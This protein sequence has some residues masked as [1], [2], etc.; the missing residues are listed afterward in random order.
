MGS[1]VRRGAGWL[2]FSCKKK[3]SEWGNDVLM[4]DK[5][6][7]YLAY[8]QKYPPYIP[9]R[10]RRPLKTHRFNDNIYY[11]KLLFCPF[12]HMSKR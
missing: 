11:H 8:H 9:S 12:A 5:E 7:C 3:D 1:V 2:G 6:G 10:H 4:C